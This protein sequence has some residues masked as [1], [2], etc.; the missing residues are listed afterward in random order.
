[1]RN[2]SFQ[3][4]GIVGSGRMG[5]DIFYHLNDFDYSLVWIFRKQDL[6][7]RALEKFNKKMK[8]MHEAGALD[9]KTYQ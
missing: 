4:I 2:R 8:R 9:D 7:N 3:K 5:E 6:K 1:M